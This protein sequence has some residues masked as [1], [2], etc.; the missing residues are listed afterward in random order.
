[1]IV[2]SFHQTIATLQYARLIIY[3]HTG[4]YIILRCC[5]HRGKP[6]VR[7]VLLVCLMKARYLACISY[8]I[9]THSIHTIAATLHHFATD[10]GPPWI[11]WIIS[12]L[13]WRS[14]VFNTVAAFVSTVTV[15][16]QL[17]FLS[18]FSWTCFFCRP[19]W[20]RFI[21]SIAFRFST[22]DDCPRQVLVHAKD[23][24]F[25]SK[26]RDPNLH[27]RTNARQRYCRNH[28]GQDFVKFPLQ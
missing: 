26:E 17:L 4:D 1:M 7:H 8:V 5:C 10:W 19:Q 21:F 27:S 3:V 11:F 9:N 28:E 25:A 13:S 18:L 12:S 24:R 20:I 16:I 14:Y 23:Q 6:A 2:A 15:R 22:D